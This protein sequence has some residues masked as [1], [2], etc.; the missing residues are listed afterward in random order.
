[1]VRRVPI[2]PPVRRVAEPLIEAG[3]LEVEGTAPLYNPVAA[4]QWGRVTPGI[5]G[6]SRM[7]LIKE[8]LVAATIAG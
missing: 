8:D 3:C 6:P 4:P 7:N 1:V 2:E 5:L